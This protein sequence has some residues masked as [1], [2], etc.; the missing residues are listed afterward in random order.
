MPPRRSPPIAKA[1]WGAAPKAA[2]SRRSGFR[3]RPR[4]PP[5]WCAAA[6]PGTPQLAHPSV[7]GGGMKPHDTG[8]QVREEPLGVARER[9]LGL[10]AP[11][12]LEEGESQ[13]LGIREPLQ[14][15]VAVSIRVEPGVGIVD[16]AK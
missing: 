8:E 9:S 15:L 3:D 4:D 7:E 11:Q 16:E 10:D 6:A 2:S 1:A 12:L 14:G 13:H 5:G